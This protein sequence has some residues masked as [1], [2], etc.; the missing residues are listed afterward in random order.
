[1]SIAALYE[2]GDRKQDK[3][4]FRNIVLIAK[5]DGEI[6]PDELELLFKI[7][8]HIDLTEDEIKDITKNPEKYPV[9]PPANREE[10]F[11]QMINLCQMVEANGEVKDSEMK[12]LE[13][14]AVSIGYDSLDEVDVESIF[15]LI[16]RG[17]DEET[18]MTELFQ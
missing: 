18:I 15:A 13:K 9:N 5:A 16:I 6:T 11:S 12:V 14:V 17:E 8:R 2:T 4:H 1:M 7:G 3:G 10:R